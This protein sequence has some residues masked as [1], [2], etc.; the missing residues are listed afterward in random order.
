MPLGVPLA[1]GGVR[2]LRECWRLRLNTKTTLPTPLARLD[3]QL[4]HAAATHHRAS[5]ME[6]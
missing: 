1:S 4:K 5:I 3:T 6:R 2:S